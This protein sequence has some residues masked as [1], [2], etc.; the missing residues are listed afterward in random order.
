ML[1]LHPKATRAALFRR[2][3]CSDGNN[4]LNILY[5]H[6]LIWQPVAIDRLIF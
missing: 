1:F 6:Y 5:V 3:F 4:I 2:T